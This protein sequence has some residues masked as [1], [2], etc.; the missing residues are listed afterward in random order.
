MTADYFD[1]KVQST[2]KITAKDCSMKVEMD[3][4]YED[5]IDALDSDDCIRE[6]VLEK[7]RDICINNWQL[8]KIS[9]MEK[10]RFF[11]ILEVM[12]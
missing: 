6:W 11:T 3:V 9:D 2:V 7:M 1:L 12:Q 4:Y 5:F 10:N 8:G